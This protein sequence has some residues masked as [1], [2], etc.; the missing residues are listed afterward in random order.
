MRAAVLRGGVLQA[1]E[2]PAPRPVPGEAV[3]DVLL[4]GVCETDLQLAAG[5]MGFQGVPGHEFVGRIAVAPDAPARVGELV[6]GEIN[7]ACG[8]CATCT[9]GLPRHCARRTVLGILG[10]DGAFAEQLALPL[11]NLHAVPPGMALD[12]AVFVEPVAA[13][14]EIP[15]QV[16]V[17]GRRVL[18]L[19][20][21]RL[22][23]LC[24]RV[25]RLCG[26][27][28][29][30][31]GRRP[32][33]LALLA[34][35]GV[36]T[37]VAAAPDRS[38]DVVVD[39][40]GSP[41]GFA[42]AC[43]WARPRGTVVLKTTCAGDAPMNLAPVVIDELTVVGSRC[44]PFGP[45]IATLASGGLAPETTIGGRFSL[46]RIADAF[47]YARAPSDPARRKALIEIVLA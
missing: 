41:Q 11:A 12:R 47:A 5:Y 17:S 14:F 4:A 34:A 1:E 23:A 33:P 46:E 25:L 16:E 22:G 37:L 43:R 30:V 31:A 39:A 6:V 21:G 26:A 32:E 40:T 8:A 7:A 15:S 44:G 45:A 20:A 13:A 27:D 18:V 2:R 36:P 19:G 10:R 28:V 24:A 29:T 38:F 3:I 9:G 42:T 35:D